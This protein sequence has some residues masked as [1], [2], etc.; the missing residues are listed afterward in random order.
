MLSALPVALLIT[1]I[2]LGLA[3]TMFA[4]LIADHN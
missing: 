2:G 4:L 3:G 1:T